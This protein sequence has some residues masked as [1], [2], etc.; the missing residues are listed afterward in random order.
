M[1]AEI[2]E[3]PEDFDK[4]AQ[5]VNDIISIIAAKK[6]L[7]MDGNWRPKGEDAEYAIPDLLKNARRM[8]EIVIVLKCKEDVSIKR[9]FADIEEDL[10]AEFERLMEEREQNR[11]KKREED[12]AARR[13]EAEEEQAQQEDVSPE[14]QAKAVEEAMKE[15][16][17]ARDAEEAE[18][19]ENDDEKPNLE[20][21]KEAK[22]EEI[23]A[24]CEADEQ[25][26]ETLKT[27][28]TEDW[29]AVEVLELDTS[30]ISAEFVHIKL[31]DLLKNHIKYRKDLVERAQAIPVKPEEVPVYEASYTY[32]HSKFGTNS[33]ISPFNPMKTKQFTVLY[34]ERLYFPADKDE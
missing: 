17:V 6:G 9:N 27:K 20:N 33:P 31:L 12:R 15:W 10:K 5:D 28:L 26:L 25:N 29:K 16:E 32:K 34:R 1:D 13:A 4:A 7:I 19:E 11:V 3:D 21:M 18:F 22:A 2:V 8:P 24:I 14:D 23:K 30:K